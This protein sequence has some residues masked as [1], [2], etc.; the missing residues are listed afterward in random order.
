MANHLF[1]LSMFAYSI[2]TENSSVLVWLILIFVPWHPNDRIS[3]IHTHTRASVKP[4]RTHAQISFV[5]HHHHVRVTHI[6]A[7]Q[8]D[9]R[10]VVWVRRV[11]CVYHSTTHTCRGNRSVLVCGVPVYGILS[12]NW[13][14]NRFA[15]SHRFKI[16]V[17]RHSVP[18]H[19]PLRPNAH[20]THSCLSFSL[21]LMSCR[22]LISFE[23]FYMFA[24][25]FSASFTKK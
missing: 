24:R 11:L 23:V 25:F 16:A 3:C 10:Y 6:V 19:S 22:V 8:L 14:M 18:P 21:L 20:S 2:V 9:Q 1:R 15:I 4:N 7:A 12:F 17:R 13:Q 5:Q